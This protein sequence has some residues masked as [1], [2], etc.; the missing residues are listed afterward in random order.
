MKYKALNSFSGAISMAKDEIR[1]LTDQ[2]L[3]KDITKAGYIMPY[4][5]IE[6][7]KTGVQTKKGVNY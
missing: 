1:E 5:K 3:I 2:A 4:E 7:S 6:K